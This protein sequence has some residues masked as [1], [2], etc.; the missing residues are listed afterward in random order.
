MAGNVGLTAYNSKLGKKCFKVKKDK[1]NR[2]LIIN[3][4][5]VNKTTWG[6]Q[7]I[8]ERTESLVSKL[9]EANKLTS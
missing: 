9:V 7:E 3:Q 1:L 6:E 5:I 8:L 4:D 2:A